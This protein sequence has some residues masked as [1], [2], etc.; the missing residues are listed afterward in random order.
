MATLLEQYNLRRNSEF[1]ARVEQAVANLALYILTAEMPTSPN[2]VLRYKWA[3]FAV[4][5]PGPYAV[6]MMPALLAD[7]VINTNMENS[8]D[9]DIT[10]AVDR[11]VVLFAEKFVGV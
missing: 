3:K 1:L 2:Y 5:S 6:Q 10:A 9:A 8:T 4:V 7:G 11:N